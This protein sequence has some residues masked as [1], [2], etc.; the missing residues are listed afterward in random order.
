M[1]RPLHEPNNRNPTKTQNNHATPVGADRCVGPLRTSCFRARAHTQVRPYEGTQHHRFLCRGGACPARARNQHLQP[2]QNTKYVCYPCRGRPMCRP[3]THKPHSRTGAHTGALL[4]GSHASS[5]CSLHCHFI[6]FA[7]DNS[8][9]ICYIIL[10]I[11]MSN[12]KST[13]EDHK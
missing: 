8:K 6:R 11:R 2:H 9:K 7:I 3:A 13:D 4:Q 12:R 10:R 5:S 1:P